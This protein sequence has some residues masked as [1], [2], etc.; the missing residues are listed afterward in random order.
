MNQGQ[1][2]FYHFFMERTANDKKED[3]R[4]LLEECFAMQDAGS[5]DRNYFDT[6][7][8][9]LLALVKPEALADVKEAVNHFA[10]KL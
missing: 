8:P 7:L 5:F 3:A 6:V 10:S 1:E 9:H 2:L 4:N